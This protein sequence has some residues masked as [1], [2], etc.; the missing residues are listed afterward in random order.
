MGNVRHSLCRHSWHSS[1]DS[2]ATLPLST[3]WPVLR[4][5]GF[6]FFTREGKF[7]RSFYQCLLKR[8]FSQWTKSATVSATVHCCLPPISALCASSRHIGQC[9][10]CADC[11]YLRRGGCFWRGYSPN[12]KKLRGTTYEQ[13]QPRHRATRVP[14]HRRCPARLALFILQGG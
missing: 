3:S 7:C 8:F 14:H 11:L 5:L 9:R 12:Q 6:C 10:V 13:R 2:G 1:A 4:S